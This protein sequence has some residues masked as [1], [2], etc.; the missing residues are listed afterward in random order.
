MR[1]DARTVRALRIRAARRAVGCVLGVGLLTACG[2]DDPPVDAS[3]S[4]API[5]PSALPS[6]TA[7][8]EATDAGV[9]GRVIAPR[10]TGDVVT[11]LRSPWS[12]AFLPGGDA[13]VSQR[14]ERS[15]VRVTAGGDVIEVGE[16]PGVEPGGEGG[17]L[18]LAISPD[19]ETDQFVYAYFTAESDNRIVRMTYNGSAL[20]E[21][22]VVLDGIAKAGIHNGGRIIFGPDGMLYA[23]TGDAG[24]SDRSQDMDSLNGKILRV[25]PDG[26]V[27]PDNPYGNP[28]WSY[29]HRNVQGLGFADDGR[30]WA[31]E[32]GQSTWDELNLVERGSNY[33]WPVAEGQAGADGMVDPVEQWS[34]DDASPS[35]LAVV[36][37]QVFMA[38]L[39]GERLWHIP[40]PGTSTSL[41]PVAYFL[42]DYGRLRD[43]VEAPD[44][45]LWVLTSNTDGRGIVREGD[46]RILR[47]ERTRG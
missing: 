27:P 17:L 20:G 36:D 33:G 45:S 14:D 10:V 12:I 7:S 15:V 29:G 21:P 5:A 6:Q 30:L 42:E 23:G 41:E 34:T 37:N 13:L 11:G 38:A 24:Q 28:V 32:F 18:G 35:G 44:G 26:S 40:A 25:A 4:A 1:S 9:T 19:F 46:D 8:S 16:V 2:A 3:A 43:V 47:V 39:G 31:S 22:E